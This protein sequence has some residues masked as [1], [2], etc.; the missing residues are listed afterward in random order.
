MFRHGDS[1]PFYTSYYY[2]S[3]LLRLP[4]HN[5]VYGITNEQEQMKDFL[6]SETCPTTT[7]ATLYATTKWRFLGRGSVVR[8]TQSTV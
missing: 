3:C 2:V 8:I 1:L 6:L 5:A 4:K 7:T